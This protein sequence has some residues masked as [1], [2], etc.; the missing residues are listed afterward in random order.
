MQPTQ[1]IL[2]LKLDRLERSV[3]QRKSSSHCLRLWGDFIRYRDGNECIGCQKKKKLAAHHILR[4]SFL[5]AAQ[6]QT[7]NGITLCKSCHGEAHEGFNRKANLR[8]PM[9]AQGGEKIELLTALFGALIS[10]ARSRN[11]LCDEFYFLSD[12]VLQ[13]FKKFQS[14]SP[15]THFPGNRI[16]QA[17]LIWKQTPQNM[18]NALLEA[19]GIAPPRDFIQTGAITIFY[20]GL[21]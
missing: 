6:F 4:K 10:N 14:F 16:E 8:L 17:F 11:L 13:A 9:D 15:T 18:R 7:G 5:G 20:D 21:K 3:S 2:K 12:Q 19:N 1:D